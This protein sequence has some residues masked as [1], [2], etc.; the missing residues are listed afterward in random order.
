[1]RS[2]S[3]ALR[4]RKITRRMSRGN[5]D[6]DV[7]ADEVLR[8]ETEAKEGGVIARRFRELGRREK[9]LGKN[10]LPVPTTAVFIAGDL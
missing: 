3:T 7:I 8:L 5:E 10:S 1:M 6:K 4:F 2:M 9:P